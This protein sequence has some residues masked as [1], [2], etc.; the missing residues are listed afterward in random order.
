MPVWGSE[1]RAAS[2][3]PSLKRLFPL[4]TAVRTLEVVYTIK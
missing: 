3:N 2:I 4:A 1:F